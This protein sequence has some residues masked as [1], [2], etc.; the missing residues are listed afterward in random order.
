M[1]SMIWTWSRRA[2]LGSVGFPR[3]APNQGGRHSQAVSAGQRLRPDAEL[4]RLGRSC[5]ASCWAR[6][7][8]DE[9]VAGLARINLVQQGGEL[10]Y[11]LLHDPGVPA[12]AARAPGRGRPAHPSQAQHRPAGASCWRG[13][14][15]G[16]PLRVLRGLGGAR[17]SR[18]VGARGHRAAATTSSGRASRYDEATGEI[19]SIAR[20]SAGL[21][22]GR[23]DRRAAAAAAGEPGPRRVRRRRQLG[24]PRDAAREPARTATRS[25]CRRT[26]YIA[27]IARRT[28]LSDDALS[29]LVPILEDIVG[30]RPAAHPR[31]VRAPG[32]A[33]PGV[34]QDPHRHP[35]DR[36]RR[37][38]GA[39]RG[40]PCL[41]RSAGW[42]R[43]SS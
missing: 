7:G 8:F 17:G 14:I 41:R 22:Q 39:A 38:P 32:P 29:V 2:Y 28:I 24:R 31:A 19:E 9:K 10:A 25:R 13:G 30:W 26:K 23:R 11:L 34:G 3:T 15:D 40:A 36:R 18:A 27:P 33:D 1:Q 4:Q 37:Q 6:P 21:R 43:R 12:R 5:C 16:L 42:R 20:V 35:D